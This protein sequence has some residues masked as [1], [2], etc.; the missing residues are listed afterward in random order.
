VSPRESENDR[1]TLSFNGADAVTQASAA[2]R[3]FGEAQWLS[4]DELARLS[5]V[6]EELVANLYDHGGVTHDDEIRMEMASEPRGIRIV[7]LDPGMPFDP[8][9]RLGKA[10]RPD[11]GGGAGIDIVRAWAQ[12]VSYEITDEGNRTELVLPLLG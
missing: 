9:Q 6:I 3:A 12:L 11:R 5:I 8:R 1:T 2:A 7:I 10:D 4:E